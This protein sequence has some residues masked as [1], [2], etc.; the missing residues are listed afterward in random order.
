VIL[1]YSVIAMF[2][3][4]SK[5]TEGPIHPLT[6]RLGQRKENKLE[7]ARIMVKYV[8]MPIVLQL[9]EIRNILM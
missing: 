1:E 9:Y 8:C 3:L 4:I 7:E 6:N 2:R 5:D